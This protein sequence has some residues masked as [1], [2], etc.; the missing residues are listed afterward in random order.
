MR[1]EKIPQNT[2][3]LQEQKAHLY[4]ETSHFCST[5]GQPSRLNQT[6]L[7]LSALYKTWPYIDLTKYASCH[8]MMTTQN[9]NTRRKYEYIHFMNY[10]GKK[11]L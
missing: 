6:I 7:R 8:E 2:G 4:Q 11:I 3:Q 10:A 9:V 5:E 1:V